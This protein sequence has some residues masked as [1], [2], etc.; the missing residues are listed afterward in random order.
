MAL[1]ITQKKFSK[2]KI[3]NN[4]Y[5]QTAQKFFFLSLPFSVSTAFEWLAIVHTKVSRSNAK[6]ALSV[7]LPEE[8]RFMKIQT[9][10]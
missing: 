9:R 8:I 7:S 6:K 1:K 4:R 2:F 10:L 5:F 3:Q